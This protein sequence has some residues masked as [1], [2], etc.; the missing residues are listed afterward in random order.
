MEF[1]RAIG[2]IADKKGI[3]SASLCLAWVSS[4][5]P[6]VIPIPGTTFVI[7]VGFVNFCV[8]LIK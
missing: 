4:L 7:S 6:N 3:S 1:V 5:G 2:E 8:V